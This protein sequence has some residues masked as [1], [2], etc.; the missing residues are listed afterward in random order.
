MAYGIISSHMWDEK[1]TSSA[2]LL[3]MNSLGI[4]QFIY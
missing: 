1:A 2:P 4:G 3:I